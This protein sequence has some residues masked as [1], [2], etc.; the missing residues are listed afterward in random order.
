MMTY[1]ASSMKASNSTSAS[2][3]T[4][5]DFLVVQSAWGVTQGVVLP[6]T[7]LLSAYSPKILVTVGAVLFSAA[8][9]LTSYCIDVSLL[10]VVVAF[11]VLSS[12]GQNIAIICELTLFALSTVRTHI[13][14]K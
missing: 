6:L 5:A 12:V 14:E 3:L 2:D 1:V 7:G 9:L 11:G 8:P 13:R 10:A 4:H